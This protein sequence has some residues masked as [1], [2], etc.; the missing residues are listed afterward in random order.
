MVHTYRDPI[1]LAQER[2]ARGKSVAFRR[3]IFQ[4][5]AAAAAVDARTRCPGAG[6]PGETDLEQAGDSF[7]KWF[8]WLSAA[9]IAVEAI[10]H[11]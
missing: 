7:P 4:T 9:V 11:K 1:C 5:A 3:L 8:G 10:I 6:L 2:K